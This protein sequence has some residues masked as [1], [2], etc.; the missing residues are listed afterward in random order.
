VVV[1][2]FLFL[3][4]RMTSLVSRDSRDGWMQK[5]STHLKHPEGR[6]QAKEQANIAQSNGDLR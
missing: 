1:A 3:E 6:Q 5:V 4:T 2:V